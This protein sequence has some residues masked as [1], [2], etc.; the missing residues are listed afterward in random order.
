MGVGAAEPEQR[1]LEVDAGE[2]NEGGRR[3]VPPPF[4][5]IRLIA[6]LSYPSLGPDSAT[7]RGTCAR[8]LSKFSSNMHATSAAR[9]S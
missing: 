7:A 2:N 5:T 4:R 6:R 9:R 1:N 3:F 8:Y